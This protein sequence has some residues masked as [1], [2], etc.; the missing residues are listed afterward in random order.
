MSDDKCDKTFK[1]HYKMCLTTNVTKRL[2]ATQ[3]FVSVT[4]AGA[5]RR[6]TS[7]G[8]RRPGGRGC[9]LVPRVSPYS[10]PLSRRGGSGRSQAPLQSSSLVSTRSGV[11]AETG[12]LV[13][14][15]INNVTMAHAKS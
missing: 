13:V 3:P 2:I 4:D 12:Y 10:P 5:P 11:V 7:R 1:Q 8:F 15:K 9:V 14:Y 6:V